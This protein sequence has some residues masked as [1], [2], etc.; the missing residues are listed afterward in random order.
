MEDRYIKGIH[1]NVLYAD[2]F[3]RLCDFQGQAHEHFFVNIHKWTWLVCEGCK[4]KSSIGSRIFGAWWEETEEMGQ[5]RWKHIMD[6]ED[7]LARPPMSL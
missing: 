6:Y 4:K 7:S 3:G 1:A 5:A 2:E